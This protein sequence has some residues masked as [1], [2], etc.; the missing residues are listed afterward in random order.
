[1]I[2][3]HKESPDAPTGKPIALKKAL[4]QLDDYAQRYDLMM[5]F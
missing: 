4:E 2:E 3:T 5:I 1:M